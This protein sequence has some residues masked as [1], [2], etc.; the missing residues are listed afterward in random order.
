MDK[1]QWID[2]YKPKQNQAG[3][4][5]AFDVVK[6]LDFI[7]SQDERF[8]W[9]EIWDY[10]SDSPLLASGLTLD[11]D[12]AGVWYV[13]EVPVEQGLPIVFDWE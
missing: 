7:K 1:Q 2:T 5:I 10:D 13:C 9:S 8:V 12:G 11:E 6:D 3:E 4:L